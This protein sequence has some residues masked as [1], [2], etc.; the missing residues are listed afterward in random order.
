M[1]KDVGFHGHGSSPSFGYREGEQ[2]DTFYCKKPVFYHVI[3]DVTLCSCHVN[4]PDISEVLTVFIIR[5]IIMKAI[6]SSDMLVIF[7]HTLETLSLTQY[8]QFFYVI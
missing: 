2:S 1:N 4:R 5:V 7:S 6:S 3:R 8:L